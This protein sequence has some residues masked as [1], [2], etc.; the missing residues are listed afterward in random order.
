[1]LAAT[2]QRSCCIGGTKSAFTRAAGVRPVRPSASRRGQR[3]VVVEARVSLQRERAWLDG[4]HRARAAKRGP[5][6]MR[7]AR[8]NGCDAGARALRGVSTVCAPRDR[9]ASSA[10]GDRRPAST[11]SLLV[12]VWSP[13]P[14]QKTPPS[15]RPSNP[16]KNTQQQQVR[17]VPTPPISELVT[18]E[19]RPE[20]LKLP[21][22]YHWYETMLVLQ[23][24]L[25]DEDR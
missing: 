21:A 15:A 3:S 11:A 17:G 6:P 10:G 19:Q 24:L 4:R 13:R 7:R 16:P 18:V 20:K 9:R 22:G 8:R 14:P 2:Q 12:V 1:M 23:P 5:Q 25:S